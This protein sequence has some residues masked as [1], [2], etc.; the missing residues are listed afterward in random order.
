MRS[1]LFKL[2][3]DSGLEKTVTKTVQQGR[4]TL[5]ELFLM[6]AVNK[7]ESYIESAKEIINGQI[8]AWSSLSITTNDVHPKLWALALGVTQG[9]VIKD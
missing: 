3:L 9:K 8:K 4:I 7:S 5:T 1:E 6:Q 2:Q